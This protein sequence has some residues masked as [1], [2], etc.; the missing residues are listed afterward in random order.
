MNKYIGKYRVLCERD[1][2]DNKPIN[3][4]ENTYIICKKKATIW[5]YNDEVLVLYVPSRATANYYKNC[6]E[7]V[8]CKY[9]YGDYEGQIYFYEKDIDRVAEVCKPYISGKNIKPKNKRSYKK[10]VEK[11]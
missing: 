6:L 7:N 5:R 11:N 9:E 2:R 4:G 10:I 3:N 8:C 1:L